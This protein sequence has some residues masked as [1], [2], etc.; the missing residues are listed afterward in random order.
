MAAWP[1]GPLGVR[2]GA[3]HRGGARPGR[4][5]PARRPGRDHPDRCRRG[6]PG[7]FRRARGVASRGPVAGRA[8][9]WRT[10]S[11][12]SRR[13]CS[14][15]SPS[16]W[17]PGAWTCPGPR[18]DRA[19]CDP[20]SSPGAQSGSG[21]PLPALSA[22]AADRVVHVVDDASVPGAR[23]DLA[24]GRLARALAALA[25]DPAGTAR[26]CRQRGRTR[27]PAPIR[28]GAVTLPGG[29][30]GSR[31]SDGRRDRRTGRAGTTN[32]GGR[33]VPGPLRS[34]A[35]NGHLPVESAA[36]PRIRFRTSR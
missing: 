17:T 21:R 10:R 24:L 28:G 11:T 9:P 18:P 19:P 6:P 25:G 31:P 23:R 27:R 5:R 4:T 20:R 7:T 35:C 14:I 36:F 2:P 16:G 13:T 8:A 1:T 34:A 3:G 33:P 12:R 15:A 22:A 32:A 29:G 30:R 26:P